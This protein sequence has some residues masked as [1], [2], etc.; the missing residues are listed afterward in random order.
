LPVYNGGEEFKKLLKSLDDLNDQTNIIIYD[1]G[2]I[3]DSYRIAC[4][5]G[6]PSKHKVRVI[7]GRK[8]RGYFRVIKILLRICPTDFYM[9][10]GHDDQLSNDF[11]EQFDVITSEQRD[12]ACIYTAIASMTPEGEI[13]NTWPH[14]LR[15][16]NAPDAIQGREV[17][18]TF[19]KHD[20]GNLFVAIW[21]KRVLNHTT[22]FQ[23]MKCVPNSDLILPLKKIGFLNDNMSVLRAL[24][25]NADSMVFF[26]KT[27]E[28]L[29]GVDSG[30]LSEGRSHLNKGD[31]LR[32]PLGYLS[33]VAHFMLPQIEQK[34]VATLWALRYLYIYFGI[35]AKAL[36]RHPG[37]FDVNEFFRGIG[38]IL[39]G[40]AANISTATRM[41]GRRSS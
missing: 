1:D 12:I 4:A 3:D 41:I 27:G 26:K 19:H 23:I 40:Y 35:T 33:T 20:W 30:R 8:N 39:T 7:D 16:D 29:K 17:L 18:N 22:L 25:H 28:Y 13:I 15:K 9:F 10:L 32:S 31:V 21:S 24:S 14:F 5:F 34:G 11:L 2:S 37:P 38:L 6:E 36:L